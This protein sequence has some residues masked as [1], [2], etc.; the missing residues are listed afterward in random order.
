MEM[1]RISSEITL[2]WIKAPPGILGNELA[3]RLDKKATSKVSL[4]ED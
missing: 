3:D 4:T 1:A 2:S